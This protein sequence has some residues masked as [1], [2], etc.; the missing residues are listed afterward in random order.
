[1]W[2]LLVALAVLAF[3]SVAGATTYIATSPAFDAMHK[4]MLAVVIAFA[5]AGGAVA[6]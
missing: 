6:C 1:M 3:L 2:K 5:V 4:L